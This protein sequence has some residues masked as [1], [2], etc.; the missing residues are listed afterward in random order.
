ME[1]LKMQPDSFDYRNM[2]FSSPKMRMGL[3]TASSS[4]QSTIPNGATLNILPPMLTMSTCP[5]TIS[6]AIPM[7]PELS[8]RLWKAERP[9]RKALALN[10][11]QNC[12][13]TKR[14][15]KTAPL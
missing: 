3:V 14:V 1:R 5:K 4:N 2:R 12:R 11:F 10:I 9:D 7:K 6:S 8:F 13:K 15:K